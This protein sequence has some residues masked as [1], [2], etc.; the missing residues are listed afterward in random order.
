MTSI[1][2]LKESACL[3]FRPPYLFHSYLLLTLHLQ[4]ADLDPDLQARQL[5]LCL[6]SVPPLPLSYS[7]RQYF[8]EVDLTPR[9][10][11]ILCLLDD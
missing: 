1:I 11:F 7:M 6:L 5:V 8:L 4:S 9:F 3:R 2:S 10:K